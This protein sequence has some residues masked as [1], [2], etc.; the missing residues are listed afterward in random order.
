MDPLNGRTVQR[1]PLYDFHIQLGAKMVDF[2]G[3]EMPLL[4]TSVVEEHRHTRE[5]ASFFDVSHMGRIELRG[6]D[7]E[8]L[9]QRVCTR[10]LGVTAVGQSLYSH[11]CNENGGIL[12]DVI[13]S[14]CDDHWLMVCNASNRDRIVSWLH[15]HA[16][17]FDVQI[18]DVTEATIMVAIQGPAAVPALSRLLPIPITDLKRYRFQ[19]GNVTGMSYSVARSGYTGEDGVELIAPAAAAGL[20][21]G[22]LPDMLAGDAG[23]KPAGLG[24]R[25]TLRLEAGMPLYGHELHEE[26]DSLSAG[27]AW[28]VDLDKDFIGVQRLREMARTGPAQQLVGLELAGRRIARQHA[29]VFDGDR[30]AGEVTSGTFAPTLQRSIAMAYVESSAADLGRPLAIDLGGTR[31]DAVVV[32]LPFYKRQSH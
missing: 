23:F 26:V 6:G 29:A 30:P 17:G 14:R 20:L 1:T 2:A 15:R 32:R 21:V 7:A 12:D 4:Y 9:L 28:C 19:S 27:L 13:A 25:D 3:W 5:S 22:F 16:A 8:S 11:V 31:A 24:A 18:T 10:Q